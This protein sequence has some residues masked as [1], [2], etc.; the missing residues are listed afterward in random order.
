M[1]Q[2]SHRQMIFYSNYGHHLKFDLLSSSVYN[3][4]IADDFGQQL[5]QIQ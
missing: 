3:N 2:A 4:P 5:S 1:L